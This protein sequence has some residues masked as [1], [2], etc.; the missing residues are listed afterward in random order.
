MNTKL[1][2][3]DTAYLSN[4][5]NTKLN[6]TDTALLS[7]RIN[8]KLN[9][10]DVATLLNPYFKI[11]DTTTLNLTNIFNAKLNV[12]DFPQGTAPGS[13]L[14]WNNGNWVNLA[15]GSPGQSLIFSSSGILTWG[16]IITNTAGSPSS[17][18]SLGVNTVL[19]NITI[20]TTGATGIGTATGLP[21]G[22]T[23][24]WSNNVITISGTPRSSG[25]FTY[26]IPLTGGCGNVN[27][28]GT[29]TVTFTCV[30]NQ[31]S[32][33]DNN[34]YNTVLIGTQC[35]L[36]ENLRV[37]RYN[38]GTA[39]PFDTTG[40]SVGSSSKWQN[41][42]IGAHT[43]YAHDSTATIGNLAVYG[44]LYNWYAAKGIYKTGTILSDDTLN[45]CPSGW[46]V[47]TDAEWT[48]LT[49]ELGGASVAGRKMK[50]E[51]NSYWSSESAGTDNSSGFSG[52]PGGWRS[53]NGSF[54][55]IRFQA[56]FWSATESSN[57]NAW[58]R[59]LE[60]DLGNVGINNNHKLHG[61]SVRCLRD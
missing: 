2:V 21:A 30:T 27:A 1:N 8:T 38:N 23:A 60:D 41:L 18:P 33:V 7:N 10:T 52:L 32:D 24:L 16:C 53:T 34:N 59:M 19:T 14:I 43:I 39:I 22:V 15:P 37:R 50:S 5:I 54:T 26:T 25:S 44:Y 11:V 9:E 17:S 55:N 45:I 46:H 49:T 20:S 56:F 48:T 35:W 47:P 4:R 40:G 61:A 51:G 31:I 58:R 28:T 12:T 36:K 42:T 3:T 6:V 29:I 57:S 13:I